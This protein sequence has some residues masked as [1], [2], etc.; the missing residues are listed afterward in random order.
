MLTYKTY[1]IH[2]ALMDRSTLCKLRAKDVH[3]GFKTLA[4]GQIVSPYL[5][6]PTRLLV[7]I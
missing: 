5:K 1:K 6:P 2:L 3:L 7:K 4:Q